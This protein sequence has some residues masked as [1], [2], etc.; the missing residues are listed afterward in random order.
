MNK[1]F[2]MIIFKRTG[3]LLVE[4]AVHLSDASFS[5]P[6]KIRSFL[7]GRDGSLPK[8]LFSPKGDF[9]VLWT[10]KIVEIYNATSGKLH[11]K[12]LEKYYLVDVKF[13]TNRALMVCSR[14]DVGNFLRMFDAISEEH[15]ATLNIE[16]E[17]FCLGVCL[18]SLRVAVS[19]GGSDVRL[20]QVHLPR[21]RRLSHE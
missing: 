16:G 2:E 4:S 8:G 3:E 11:S 17:N 19:L 18:N 5:S 6:R 7:E 15:L 1:K 9:V 13:I 12:L 10:S 20:I 14:E 21:S